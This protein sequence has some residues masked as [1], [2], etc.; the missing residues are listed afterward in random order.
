M[1]D[2]DRDP[3]AGDY[4]DTSRCPYCGTPNDPD[5]TQGLTP[6]SD[7][8]SDVLTLT[9]TIQVDAPEDV[10]LAAEVQRDE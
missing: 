4:A 1:F 5:E 2:A 10:E 7:G 6:A 3:K 9:V 8:G